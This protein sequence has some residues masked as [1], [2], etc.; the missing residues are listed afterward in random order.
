MTAIHLTLT[1][2]RVEMLHARDAAIASATDSL[3]EYL[4][5]CERFGLTPKPA[6]MRPMLDLIRTEATK[7]VGDI[8]MEV[9]YA[10][11]E[12]ERMAG[13]AGVV[14]TAEEWDEATTSSR[15]RTGSDPRTESNRFHVSIYEQVAA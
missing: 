12:L 9:A 11:R 10:E 4:A 1:P 14:A 2:H 8:E 13:A 15:E 6:T 3:I 7:S 5:D